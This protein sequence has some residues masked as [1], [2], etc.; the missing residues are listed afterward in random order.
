M[1]GL[2]DIIE[3][4]TTQREKT[5]HHHKMM[6]RSK[7][8]TTMLRYATRTYANANHRRHG[9][10][11]HNT[12]I[13]RRTLMVAR[14]TC[15]MDDGDDMSYLVNKDMLAQVQTDVRLAQ[16]IFGTK[17][18]MKEV[19]RRRAKPSQTNITQTLPSDARTTM[20][21]CR[22]Q[23]RD[24]NEHSL[25]NVNRQTVNERKNTCGPNTSLRKQKKR[26]E[27]W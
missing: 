7:M 18:F 23:E 21:Q 20:D 5:D 9:K 25:R 6:V 1:H 10:Q 22:V 3:Q 12:A 8:H 14:K 19:A 11:L 16:S 4:A 15:L 24:Y 27:P 17:H 26:H 13:R 2:R